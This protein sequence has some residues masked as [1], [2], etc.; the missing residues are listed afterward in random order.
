MALDAATEQIGHF[1][2]DAI[3]NNR[4]EWLN[5]AKRNPQI[6]KKTE[7]YKL[8]CKLA[9]MSTLPVKSLDKPNEIIS[10]SH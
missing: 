9:I 5:I 10:V 6:I 1:D 7:I 2:R 3:A 8:V 4:L